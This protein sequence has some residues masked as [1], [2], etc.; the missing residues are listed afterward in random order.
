MADS[1]AD[2]FEGASCT[3]TLDTVAQ[4]LTFEHRGWGASRE[5]KALSPLVVPLGAIGAVEYR[6]HWVNGYFRIVR[7]GQQPWL[8]SIHSD[9]HALTCAEDPTEFAERVRDAVAAVEPLTEDQVE[10]GLPDFEAAEEI[11]AK[12]TTGGRVAGGI[13][14]ALINGFF[15]SR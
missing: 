12:P 13:G 5:Q 14:R 3:A 7:R 6:K 9:P 15:N 2:R 4:T 8:H 1:D 11:A 10:D